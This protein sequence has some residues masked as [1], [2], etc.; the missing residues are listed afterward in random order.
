MVKNSKKSVL[1]IIGVALITTLFLVVL[2]LFLKKSR[3][4]EFDSAFCQFQDYAID[5]CR[6][7]DPDI[8]VYGEDFDYTE[9]LPLRK[10]VDVSFD[11][12]E[13]ITKPYKALVVMDRFG[14]AEL[15]REDI[16]V[17][18]D[19][20]QTGK[21]DFYYLGTDKL[22]LFMEL[23]LTTE[24]SPGEQSF[25]YL[26][27]QRIVWE[28]MGYSIPDENP[29]YIYAMHGLFMQ[30][31]GDIQKEY[32]RILQALIISMDSNIKELMEVIN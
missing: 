22:Q 2:C 15:S 20:C 1:I 30:E 7:Y 28:K 24:L 3:S 4:L 12:F 9:Y 18:R 29:S 13:K 25:E 6:K 27:S 19:Y 8:M 23:G 26:G 10:I 21:M 14:E 16:I 5:V 17:I 11:E 32:S 31:D